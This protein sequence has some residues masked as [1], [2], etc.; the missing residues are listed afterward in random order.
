MSRLPDSVTWVSAD[1]VR[2]R[3]FDCVLYQSR[4]SW[5]VDRETTLSAEQQQLP[6]IY[7]EHRP[8]A[9]HPTDEPHPV[10]DPQT[11]LVHVSH[12]NALAWASGRTPVRVIEHGVQVPEGV[13][14][15]GKLTRGVTA[16]DDLVAGGRRLGADVFAKVRQDVPVDLVGELAQLAGGLGQVP[17]SL[18][19]EFMSAYRFY[20]DP[21]RQCGPS[22][23][24]CEAMMVGLPVVALATAGMG[25][26]VQSGVS[27]HV[28][29]NPR[30]LVS[31]MRELLASPGEAWRLG[32]G[33]RR[34]ARERFELRRFVRD[35][36]QALR[37][38]AGGVRWIAPL[39]GASAGASLGA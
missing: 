38:V 21:T 32:Q 8:P 10:D 5:I 33:A 11:L 31:R 23:E 4:E 36:D 20:F 7:V 17:P 39:A 2:H 29:P 6:R 22:L 35:W 30:V 3:S 34:T 13:L 18:L 15:S 1:E 16:I 26:L 24:L 37:S 19:A 25:A 27:G 28:D 14:Y 9:L 12:F